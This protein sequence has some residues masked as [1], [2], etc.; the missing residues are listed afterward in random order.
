[1][2]WYN[3]IKRDSLKINNL[4]ENK[5]LII[6]DLDG[7]LIDSG[8][9][10]AEALN[11]MLK[12]LGHE[13]FS[14]EVIHNWVGNGALT[15]VKRG[16]LGKNDLDNSLND[17]LVQNAL[18]IFLEYYQENICVKTSAYPH[19]KD[20]LEKLKE[21]G[22][23]LSIVTNK[24]YAFIKPILKRLG[25]QDF[26][27]LYVGGDSLELKKPDPAP[28]LYVCKSLDIDVKDSI[29]IG[30]SKNDIL[31][32][33]R[34]NMQSIGVNYGYNYGEDIKT[35]NPTVVVD[36]FKNILTVLENET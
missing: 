10:L 29:M 25:L 19:V 1:M 21:S 14:E 28:L 15:L 8:P 16:L 22:Y 24:P 5:K 13:T 26:F 31:A 20:T 33:N 27:E 23:I 12:N 4:I 36:D 9:D 18:E 32:A 6:F 3:F 7:T 35:H 34:C 30:D 2:F 17:D 11:Y